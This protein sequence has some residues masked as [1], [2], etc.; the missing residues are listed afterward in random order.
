MST[1]SPLDEER[2]APGRTPTADAAERWLRTPPS[3]LADHV[4][5]W[6]REVV[7]LLGAVADYLAPGAPARS[8]PAQA[9]APD[10]E[11]LALTEGRTAVAPRRPGVAGVSL[12]LAGCRDWY[13][14]P[15][16]AGR[17]CPHTHIEI[18]V[19]EECAQA[20]GEAGYSLRVINVD[21]PRWCHAEAFIA[22]DGRW[23]D[24]DGAIAAAYGLACE[25]WGAA[26]VAVHVTP[27]PSRA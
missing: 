6:L 2:H 22:P 21:L 4:E 3:P 13:A 5:W 18:L 8:E 25:R 9:A 14:R 16:R 19:R 24:R 17:R 12:N 11:A 20:G 15:N 7:P 23:E 10:A 26:I 1:P 27:A